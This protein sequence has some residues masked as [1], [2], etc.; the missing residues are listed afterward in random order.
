LNIEEQIAA[1]MEAPDAAREVVTLDRSTVEAML[2]ELEAANP[3][4]SLVVELR[5]KLAE[6]KVELWAM[7]TVGP[8]EIYPARDREHADFMYAD[9][10]AACAREKQRCIDAGENMEYWQDWQAAI[11][12]S[13]FEPDQHFEILAGETLDEE[14]RIRKLWIK[15]DEDRSKLLAAAAHC[16]ECLTPERVAGLKDIGV[17]DVLTLLADTVTE[18][19]AEEVARRKRLEELRAGLKP[20]G[21]AAD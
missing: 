20:E 14:A 1:L 3:L 19:T 7:Y 16:L 21:I 5:A 11:I 18:V 9:L 4:R 12:P 8:G 6:P 17:L 13:P 2:S 10:M 15:C